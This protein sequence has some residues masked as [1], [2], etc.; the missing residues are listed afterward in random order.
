MLLFANRKS[1]ELNVKYR[2]LHGL[3]CPEN[4]T[5]TLTKECDITKKQLTQ[6]IQI[7]K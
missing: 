6:M 4:G 2:P 7:N 1:K 3:L 5:N